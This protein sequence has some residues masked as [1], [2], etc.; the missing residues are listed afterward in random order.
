MKV[1]M[2]NVINNEQGP[3]STVSKSFL[4]RPKRGSLTGA[5][6]EQTASVVS[7]LQEI[8]ESVAETL[9]DYR[10]ET[11]DVATSLVPGDA[12]DQDPYSDL[13]NLDKQLEGGDIKKG[14]GTKLRKMKR[15][16][17]VNL[18]RKSEAGGPYE[19]KYL[20]PG[21][22][23]DQWDLYRQRQQGKNTASFTTFWRVS[24]I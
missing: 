22:M 5:P 8:Y 24:Q 15:S 11:W 23:K 14:K 12:A 6:A 10:D 18:D 17:K 20:P 9:P 16:I 1:L 13:Q 4:D 2:W 3:T 7:F 19:E 21:Q